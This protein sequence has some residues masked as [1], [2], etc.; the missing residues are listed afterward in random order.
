MTDAARAYLQTD[1]PVSA[2]RVL[3]RADS[4]APAEVRHRPAVREVVGQVA[5]DPDAPATITQ[6]AI[7]L[8]VL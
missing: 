4:I 7:N 2:A 5:R 8:G 3:M 1:D 6:L